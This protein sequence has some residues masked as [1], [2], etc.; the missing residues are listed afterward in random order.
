[1]PFQAVPG[2]AQLCWRFTIH[3]VPMQC[4]ISLAREGTITEGQLLSLV[5][6]ML[7]DYVVNVAPVFSE[8]LLLTSMYA[9][10]LEDEIAPQAEDTNGG[11]PVPGE[12]L[13][14]I[15]NG[16]DAFVLGFGS[17][18]TGRSSRGR[19]FW[20]GIAENTTT[21]GIVPPGVAEIV[22]E[23]LID[24]IEVAEGLGWTHVITS[25]WS[26]GELR[27][28]GVNQVVTNYS[29]SALIGSQRN[30]RVGL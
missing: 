2:T 5:I 1:M 9:R 8:E 26:N 24:H 10:S 3:G 30:R 17:G 15:E 4:C 25:R 11:V 29:V 20:P 21:D 13:V 6:S 19:I 7:N 16:S 23:A 12:V 28:T 18:Q 22:A 27:P 14:V